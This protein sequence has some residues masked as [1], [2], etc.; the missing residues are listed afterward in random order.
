M[1]CLGVTLAAYIWGAELRKKAGD[2]TAQ[3]GLL[4]CLPIFRPYLT[5]AG[6]Y[7]SCTEI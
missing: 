3:D 2:P 5:P 6:S 4:L 1:C 7:A